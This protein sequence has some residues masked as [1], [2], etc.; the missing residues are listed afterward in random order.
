M[1]SAGNL[2]AMFEVI[3]KY[4]V[5]Y[6]MMHMRHTTNNAEYDPLRYRQRN[7]VLFFRKSK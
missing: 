4:K 1:I 6:I 5:P 2:D 3:A 7:T